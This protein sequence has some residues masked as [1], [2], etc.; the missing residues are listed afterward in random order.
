MN[1]EFNFSKENNVN[2]GHKIYKWFNLSRELSK[3]F[4]QIIDNLYR[5]HYSF[6]L[7]YLVIKT[8]QKVQQSLYKPGEKVQL[9]REK[10]SQKITL[11]MF[12][13]QKKTTELEEVMNGFPVSV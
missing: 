7:E 1:I 8:F 5:T 9:E 6:N 10:M 12:T 13:G 11:E 4:Y 3:N 2:A